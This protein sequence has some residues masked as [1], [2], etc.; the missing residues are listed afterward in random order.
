MRA[1]LDDLVA[2]DTV[3]GSTG[4][5]PAATGAFRRHA[6][7]ARA[8]GVSS[9]AL[10]AVADLGSAAAWIAADATRRDLSRQLARQALRFAV[11]AGD[12]RMR[13]FLHAHL[14]MVCEHAGR[15]TDALTYAEL[16]LAEPLPA[17]MGALFE[18]RRARALSGLG[19]HTAALDGWR[20][21][22]SL[23]TAC[24]ADADPL[25]G[26]MHD[27][28]MTLHQAVILHR[29]GE[30]AAVDLARRAVDG[31]PAG[32]SRD[33]VLFAAMHL[34]IAV[35]AGAWPEA[36]DTA[37]G[38]LDT[39]VTVSARVPEVLDAARLAAVAARAPARVVDAVAAVTGVAQRRRPPLQ[40]GRGH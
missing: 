36:V 35:D 2:W 29:A 20:H 6:R 4:L 10:A 40:L 37:A 3:H 31:L 9:D 28:E 34:Q 21:A 27:A 16:G 26:W 18:L 30:P 11:R 38:L 33:R 22:T 32:S 24:T 8:G 19:A 13:R 14:S 12:T 25:T 39:D 7:P 15:Y 5:V 23:L 1:T 17:R